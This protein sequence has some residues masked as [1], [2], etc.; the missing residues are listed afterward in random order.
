[1]RRLA[2]S[3][4]L[5][6]DR[7]ALPYDEGSPIAADSVVVLSEATSLGEGKRH[8]VAEVIVR[9]LQRGDLDNDIGC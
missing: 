9:R 4:R 5:G 8:K 3:A 1:L 6:A 7:R 2:D